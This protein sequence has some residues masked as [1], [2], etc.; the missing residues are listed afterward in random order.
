MNLRDFWYVAAE[1]RA[2]CRG[3]FLARVILGQHLVLFRDAAGNAVALE[4]RC[5]HRN[6]PL[7]I[8]KLQD[9]TLI[10]GYHGWRYDAEGRV[11]E[12]PSLVAPAA[13]GNRCAKRFAVREQEDYVY[14]RLA[15]GGEAHEPFAMPRWTAP[16][17]R[18][19][20]LVHTMRNDVGNCVENFID[21]PHTAY[22]HPRSFRAP[23]RRTIHADVVR[24]N[25]SVT[26]TYRDEVHRGAFAWFLNPGGHATEHVDRF[27]M[28]NVTSVEY[29]FGPRRHLFITSQSVA[30]REMETIVYTDV[31][32]DFGVWNA[33]AAPF[34]RRR[35]K[36]IIAEDVAVLAAQGE[37]IARSG[38]D[39]SHVP[40][41]VVHVFVEQV[42]GELGNG[43][44]PRALD[45][46]AR[47]ISFMV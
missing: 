13:V 26:V 18:H 19:V 41:D 1:S 4:D 16:G 9:G 31:T 20:R 7:S 43:R 17:W 34:V 22:V 29:R 21:V 2:L 10:C 5:A 35:A 8:G 42:L 15:D 40:A 38:R 45:R 37:V 11:T 44:D 39:F 46:E 30:A 25:G 32:F 3:A 24:E 6:A 28:P 47:T 27:V 14:V 36:R 23:R 12:I 33:V